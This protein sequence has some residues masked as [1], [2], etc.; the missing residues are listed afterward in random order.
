[1][2]G[3]KYTA[4]NYWLT[5]LLIYIHFHHYFWNWKKQLSKYWHL[6]NSLHLYLMITKLK[7][8]L[9]LRHY[10]SPFVIVCRWLAAGRWFSVGT[11]VKTDSHEITEILL[12][13]VLNTITRHKRFVELRI[14]SDYKKV[15]SM[16]RCEKVSKIKWYI[17]VL[18][19]F[20][21]VKH[22]VSLNSISIMSTLF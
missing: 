15:I 9:H 7:T 16:Q 13:I 1:M 22:S 8:I 4:N 5:W 11:P 12:K 6:Q 18:Y 10:L 20:F 17:A 2:T 14:Y 3:S 19:F 21:E